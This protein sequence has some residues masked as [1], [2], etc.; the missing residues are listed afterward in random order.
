[1][2]RIASRLRQ[3]WSM[4]S[5]LGPRK[6]RDLGHPRASQ[7]RSRDGFGV[8]ETKIKNGGN[9]YGLRLR[10]GIIL[11]GLTATTTTQRQGKRIK[12]RLQRQRQNRT[13][14]LSFGPDIS[15]FD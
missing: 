13:F 4:G 2:G 14:L 7:P 10:Y 8:D 3:V 5:E 15:T 6:T 12:P 9:G 11:V 1:M